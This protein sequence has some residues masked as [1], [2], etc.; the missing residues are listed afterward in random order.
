MSELLKIKNIEK[1]FQIEPGNIYN[2]NIE[3]QKF[4]YNLLGKL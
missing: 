1:D 4:Y 2:L 3:N